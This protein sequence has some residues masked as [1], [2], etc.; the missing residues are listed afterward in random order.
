MRK[1]INSLLSVCLLASAFVFVR[2]SNA[3]A[4]SE[5]FQ[6]GIFWP[7]VSAYSNATQ[8]DYIRDAHINLIHNV[9]STDLDTV[10]ENL[11]MLNLASTRGI[12]ISVADSRSQTLDSATNAQIDAIA[13]DYKNHSATHGYY[14]KDEPLPATFAGFARAYNRFLYNHPDSEPYVNLLPTYYGFADYPGYLNQWVET[15]GASNLKTLAYDNYPW[16]SAAQSIGA[17]YFKT[18]STF[19]KPA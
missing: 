14:V 13:A 16:K 8:F 12:E 6:I 15:V 3:S 19:G 4:A 17:D 5:D 9:D 1:Q 2:P 11:N 10:A 18:W 7:L